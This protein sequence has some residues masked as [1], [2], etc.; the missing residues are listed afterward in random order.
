MKN[1]PD[2]TKEFREFGEYVGQCRT[3]FNILEQWDGKAWRRVPTAPDR[4][5]YPAPR[6]H[7]EPEGPD[8]PY[9]GDEAF[10]PNRR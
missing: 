10:L 6:L 9:A 3:V 5:P 1:A 8:N 2:E 4:R 7:F